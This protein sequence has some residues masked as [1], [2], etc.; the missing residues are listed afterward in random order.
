MIPESHAASRRSA[1]APVGGVG[2][3]FL[4]RD[5]ALLVS[6]LREQSPAALCGLVQVRSSLREQSR[7]RILLR[8]RIQSREKFTSVQPWAVLSCS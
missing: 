6:G 2:V 3:T 7:E 8:A 5:G 1:G 4:P